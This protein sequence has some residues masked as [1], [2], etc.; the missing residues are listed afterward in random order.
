VSARGA[1]RAGFRLA[2]TVL[3]VGA[4][5]V[6]PSNNV[7]IASAPPRVVLYGDSVLSSGALRVAARVE[8]NGWTPHLVAFAGADVEQMANVAYGDTHLG[9]VVVMTGGYTYFWKPWVMGAQIDKFL[10]VLSARGVHRVIWLNLREARGQFRDVNEALS[11]AA[12]RWRFLDIA[13]WNGF[14]RGKNSAFEADGYHLRPAGGALMGALIARRLAAYRAG[15]PRVAAVRYAARLR[16]RPVLRAYRG[17][18]ATAVADGVSP[19]SDRRPFVG[20]ASAPDGQG[21]WLVD[22]A[23]A[24]VASGD[25]SNFGSVAPARRTAPIVGIASTPSGRGY[26]IAGS[27]GNVYAFGDAPFRGG[28]RKVGLRAPV[29]GIASTRSGQGYWLAAADGGV[30]SFGDARFYGSTGALR[31][32]QPIVGIAAHPGGRG[33]W[34]VAYDGGVFAFGAARFYGSAGTGYRYWKVEGIAPTSRGTGYWLLDAC[35]NLLAFNAPAVRTTPGTYEQL[36]VAIAPRPRDGV[37]VLGQG[38]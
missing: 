27:D 17:A 36:F 11:A 1:V 3:I 22:R 9:D 25:A 19:I 10:T 28:A 31:L 5:F 2:V 4:P 34:L 37:F 12:R 21:A 6:V 20:L 14:T 32:D 7:A 26:W 13:D 33:Y 29:V 18:D 23:G 16:L 35:G 15:A 8:A 30:F 24:V 38:T